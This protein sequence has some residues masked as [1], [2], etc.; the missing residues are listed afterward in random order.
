M[1]LEKN[2]SIVEE[3]LLQIKNLEEAINENAKGILAST[4]K[5]EISEL[6]KE[7]LG[8]SKKWIH[9]QDD[10]TEVE[11]TNEPQDTEGEEVGVEDEGEDVD[12]GAAD[13]FQM[14]DLSVDV[15]VG[16]LQDLE[17]PEQ[18][19]NEG[20]MPPL[21]MTS[22]PMSDIMKVFK[23]MG[24]DDGIIVK[25]D[26]DYIHLSDGEENVEYLIS[27]GDDPEEISQEQMAENVIYELEVEDPNMM[28][29]MYE[30][31]GIES[32]EAWNMDEEDGI[33]SFEAWNMD[34]EFGM[35]PMDEEFGMD[36]MDEEFGM[37]PMDE[38][39]G[40]ESFE[41]WNMDEQ[42]D[43]TIY[44]ID[45]DDLD[46]VMEMFKPVGLGFGKSKKSFKSPK[47]D[48]K[49]EVNMKGFSDDMDE[50]PKGGGRG[51]KFKY[52]KI[53]GNVSEMDNRGF[54]EEFE[55][56]P[57][58]EIYDENMEAW[59][60]DEIYDENMEAWNMDE[61]YDE[62]MEAWNMDEVYDE[63]MEGYENPM[64]EQEYEDGEMEE[65]AR[66]YGNG[67]KEG[68]GLRKGITPNRNMTYESVN[69]EV[70]LLREKNEEYKKALDFFRNKLNEVA[71]F[72]SNLAYSTRLFTEH[73]TTKQEKI[74]ILRRFDEVD[75]LKESKSLY[76]TIKN[77][78]D[79]KGTTNTIKES[80]ERKVVKTPSNGSSSNLIESKTYENPQFL[81]MKDLMAKIK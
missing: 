12:A 17:E 30:E 27:V 15:G 13:N 74:N 33:E 52:P 11:P 36:P 61:V 31:D 41:D 46:A 35:D 5:E 29:D 19:D 66:T 25:K 51:P 81:R 54:D 56:I 70:N 72:N 59:N 34:E 63:N 23:A 50:A 42:E 18:G 28:E 79:G 80:I 22:S 9:E 40:M 71:V 45:Q 24:D 6:V 39:D 47:Y 26:D 60:M 55:M 78:L 44:E 76:R 1:K 2:N 14:D 65:A 75:T 53:K 7:S 48:M 4:M 16:N 58:D 73:S 69:S 68:R 64:D 21:D 49:G 62:N 67:S 37:D 32:F 43:E 57:F 20:E 38:E 77:E 3:A 8:G 10:E